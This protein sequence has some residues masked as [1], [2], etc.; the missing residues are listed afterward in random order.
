MKKMKKIKKILIAVVIIFIFLY[1][2]ISGPFFRIIFSG[3]WQHRITWFLYKD[4][5]EK[6]VYNSDRFEI[7]DP[8]FCCMTQALDLFESYTNDSVVVDSML[9]VLFS[10]RDKNGDIRCNDIHQATISHILCTHRYHM[11][12]YVEQL[13][14]SFD[15]YPT[16]II[17]D[18][19]MSYGTIKRNTNIKN[20]INHYIEF[21]K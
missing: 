11:L 15:S 16:D 5:I 4:N 17:F 19:E 9:I 10:F 8:S 14:D 1:N 20:E 6:Y 13:R 7:L 2:P 21:F 12:P 18:T 3:F